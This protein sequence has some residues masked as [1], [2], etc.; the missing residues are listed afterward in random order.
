LRAW[1]EE[2]TLGFLRLQGIVRDVKLN[3]NS[4]TYP[5]EITGAV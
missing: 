2:E 4:A 3:G 1:G 5:C